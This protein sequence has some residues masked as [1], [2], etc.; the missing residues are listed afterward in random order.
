MYTTW[1]RFFYD[2]GIFFSC[3]SKF[4]IYFFFYRLFVVYKYIY[5]YTWNYILF[6]F[7]HS[8]CFMD[9]YRMYKI[10]IVIFFTN[11]ILHFNKGVERRRS[12]IAQIVSNTLIMGKASKPSTTSLMRGQGRLIQPQSPEGEVLDD[13]YL[14]ELM[15]PAESR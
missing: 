2:F 13:M 14:E 1:I 8:P 6:C 12:S 10:Y 4:F 11:C 3:L 7:K 9:F 15:H 5:I